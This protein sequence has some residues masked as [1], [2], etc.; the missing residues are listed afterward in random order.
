MMTRDEAVKA[1][2]DAVSRQL[3][4]MLEDPSIRVHA[5]EPGERGPGGSVTRDV[6]ETARA[7]GSAGLVVRVHMQRWS[8]ALAPRITAIDLV[9]DLEE[10]ADALMAAACKQ[11]SWHV[12][13]ERSLNAMAEKA[14]FQGFPSLAEYTDP[15]WLKIDSAVWEAFVG[16]VGQR[17]AKGWVNDALTRM[18]EREADQN[19]RDPLPASVFYSQFRPYLKLDP[20]RAGTSRDMNRPWTWLGTRIILPAGPTTAMPQV[21]DEVGDYLP[22]LPPTLAR[23][24]IV[25]T[26]GPGNDDLNGILPSPLPRSID[27]EAE[28]VTLSDLL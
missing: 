21:G 28:M 20:L 1:V 4:F 19:S 17:N 25:R 11:M 2:A 24:T 23:R 5:M 27:Y 3:D 22:D 8:A 15:K 18:Y 14:G 9:V 6:A 16:I 26:T 12:E 7:L 13:G 10:D